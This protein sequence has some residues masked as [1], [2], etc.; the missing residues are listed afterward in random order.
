VEVY[1]GL[2]EDEK[3]VLDRLC[4]AAQTIDERSLRDDELVTR[5]FEKM[6]K[7]EAATHR[8]TY[9]DMREAK[10]KRSLIFH[11]LN[12][13]RDTYVMRFADYI[14]HRGEVVLA[15]RE[16]G[17]HVVRHFASAGICVLNRL[18]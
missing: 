12:D 11:L 13:R 16:F 3:E 10:E 4:R 17:I 15:V 1:G 2:A 18:L 5:C 7:A 8:P 9:I 6:T 14:S